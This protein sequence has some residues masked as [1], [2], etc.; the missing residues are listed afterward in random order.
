M[1]MQGRIYLRCFRAGELLFHKAETMTLNY[2][3]SLPLKPTTYL[4]HQYPFPTRHLSTIKRN[5]WDSAGTTS[6]GFR[7]IKAFI[8]NS[9]A[10]NTVSFYML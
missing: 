1:K 4:H 8:S 3:P 9:P 5:P 6:T 7:Q 2:I 10:K